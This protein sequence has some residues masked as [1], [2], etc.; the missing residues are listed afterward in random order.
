M[1]KATKALIEKRNRER[2]MRK[3]DNMVDA[4]MEDLILCL[5]KDDMYSFKT[6]LHHYLE[7]VL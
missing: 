3:I 7:D 1:A 5:T 6:T 4:I 2:R